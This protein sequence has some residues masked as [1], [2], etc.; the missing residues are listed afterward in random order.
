MT[1]LE[2]STTENHWEKSSVE[3]H[4]QLSKTKRKSRNQNILIIHNY[5]LSIFHFLN[6]Q[7]TEKHVPL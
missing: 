3:D 6:W 5:L 2:E 4:E 7:L 1:R